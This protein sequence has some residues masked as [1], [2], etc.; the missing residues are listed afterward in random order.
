MRLSFVATNLSVA[1]QLAKTRVF[2]N[3]KHFSMFSY[4]VEFLLVPECFKLYLMIGLSIIYI[5][6]FL[7]EWFQSRLLQICFMCER[8]TEFTLLHLLD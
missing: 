6:I 4:S 8:D 3:K 5:F 7:Y 2:K 1:M